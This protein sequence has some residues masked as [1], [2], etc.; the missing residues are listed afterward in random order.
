[1]RYFREICSGFPK[2][3][4]VKGESPDFQLWISAKRF[5]GIELTQIHP[6]HHDN[7]AQCYLSDEYAVRQVIGS[8]RLKE[9]KIRLYRTDHP[10][11]LWLIIFADYS[12]P[13]AMKKIM[14]EYSDNRIETSFDNVFFFD[15]DTRMVCQL[16]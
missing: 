4:L 9:E 2:G 7:A 12:E 5:I 11:K 16:T 1:M 15:L 14:D 6:D 13:Q 8:V 10:Y 3:K